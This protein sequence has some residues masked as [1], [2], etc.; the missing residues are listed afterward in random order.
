MFSKFILIGALSISCSLAEHQPGDDPLQWLR[1]SIPGEPGTDYPIFS[2]VEPTSFE[3]GDDK[4]FGGYYADPE[5]GCQAYH[6]C[7][8]DPH[9]GGMYPTSFLCPNGTL[10]QQQIFNCDWWYNVDCAA[11]ESHY[12]L[13]EGAFGAGSSG[14]GGDSGGGGDCPAANPLSDAECGGAVS[15]CWSPGQTDTDCPNYGLCC[16]DGCA[17][18]CVDDA[19]IQDDAILPD[20]IPEY[21]PDPVPS[22]TPA[23]VQTSTGYN[24]PVPEVTLPIRP[25]TTTRAPV[26]LPPTLYGAPP[27]SVPRDGRQGRNGRRGRN[28][29]RNGRRRGRNGRRVR[30]GN[31]RVSRRIS[32]EKKYVFV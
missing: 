19:P 7:L 28:G 30:N 10:F 18:T 22:P 21:V 16:F 3:C 29:G 8:L 14:N 25:V 4:V 32:Q 12:G 1:D 26:T 24:Y 5:M 2:A 23:P 15:N 13:A 17:N 31:R 27:E 20:F 11:S 6:V 9:G